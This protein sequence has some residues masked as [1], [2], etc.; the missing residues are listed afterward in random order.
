MRFTDMQVIAPQLI[1]P[2]GLPADRWVGAVGTVC[3]E[4][5]VERQRVVLLEFFRS[6]L[7]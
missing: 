2:F 5:S 3:P 7:S 1:E 6:I 4:D